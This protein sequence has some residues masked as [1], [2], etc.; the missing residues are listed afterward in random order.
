MGTDLDVDGTINLD[1][2]DIDGMRLAQI[3]LD[4]EPKFLAKNPTLEHHSM[5]CPR[6][7]NRLHFSLHGIVSYLPTRLPT[8][9][10]FNPSMCTPHGISAGRDQ[11]SNALKAGFI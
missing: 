7:N 10:E 6:T 11:A 1:V 3:E 4:E 8:Q 5:F 2:V 9:D